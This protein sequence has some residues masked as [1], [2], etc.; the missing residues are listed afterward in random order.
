MSRMVAIALC[1]LC[2]C[3]CAAQN[4][5]QP[6]QPRCNNN[7]AFAFPATYPPTSGATEVWNWGQ[8][9]GNYTSAI[10]GDSYVAGSGATPGHLYLQAGPPATAMGSVFWRNDGSFNSHHTAPGTAAGQSSGA[11]NANMQPGVSSF[12]FYFLMKIT[13]NGNVGHFFF[14]YDQQ[15]DA[16]TFNPG[17]Q[18]FVSSAGGFAPCSLIAT[19]R[20]GGGTTAEFHGKTIGDRLCGDDKWHLVEMIFDKTQPL[21]QYKVDGDLLQMVNTF[22]GPA[23]NT[24]GTILP[25]A[26]IRFGMREYSEVATFPANVSMAAAAYA[27]S[28]TYIWR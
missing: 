23:L 13:S 16:V 8:A 6:F 4:S 9:N 14:D 12:K 26:G 19:I 20:D 27:K 2:S 15:N 11:V 1:L 3:T 7:S 17:M 10:Q 25:V 18:F 22:S 21:P 28:L 5:W 24:L